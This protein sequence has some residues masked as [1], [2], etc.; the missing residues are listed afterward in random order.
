MGVR[1]LRFSLAA[2]LPVPFFL[3]LPSFHCVLHSGASITVDLKP[4]WRNL[5]AFLTKLN[6]FFTL[7]PLKTQ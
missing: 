4:Y 3:V 6:F 7:A 2:P 1:V 5:F